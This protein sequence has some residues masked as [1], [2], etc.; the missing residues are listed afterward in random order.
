MIFDI[1]SGMVLEVTDFVYEAIDLCRKKDWPGVTSELQKRY[2]AVSSEE[3]VSAL[4]QLRAKGLFKS[5]PEFG[6][7]QQEERIE[8]LWRHHPCR[9]QLV[10]SQSCNLSCIYCY[11]ENNQSNARK[12]LMSKKQAFQAVDHLIERSGRRRNLQ[13]TFFGGEPL[14]NFP[15]VKEVVHFCK[16]CEKKHGKN[17]VFEL[18]TNGTLLE[19]DIADF[20]IEHDMLLFVSLDGW[21]Q[22]HN[23]QR[24]SING[25][26]YHG[27]ILRNAKRMDSE[28]KTRKSKYPVKVRANLTPE[29]HDVNAVV[30]FLQSHGF[31]TI[32]ISAI[33]DLAYSEGRTPGALSKEQMQQLEA[34]SNDMLTKGFEDIV[35]GKRTGPYVAKVLRKTV[36]S[37]LQYHS[38]MGI[39]CG[40]GRNTNA[41]DV[42]GNIYPCHRYVNM[43]EYIVGNANMGMSEEKTKEYYRKLI[44]SACRTCSKCWIRSFCAGGCPWERS[45]PDG[46]ICAP[47]S[48]E[49]DSRRRAVEKALWMRKE[50][51]KANPELFTAWTRTGKSDDNPLQWDDALEL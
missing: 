25:Q 9:L 11:M 43:K 21:R 28:Y 50:L 16:E 15:I 49:C 27:R 39:R 8:L 35:R 23:K 40:V 14:L 30:H 29:F 24:P 36:C 34:A 41:V 46:T 22:M 37:L 26:D 1:A 44:D 12:V 48:S 5:P 4:D 7:K 42:D 32:G 33:Q 51:R 38:T 45:A 10:I 2:P 13:V 19:G 6:Q 3:L 18:I 17:F 20:V 47:I 31:T